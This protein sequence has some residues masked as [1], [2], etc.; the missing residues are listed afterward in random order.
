MR[1]REAC[2]HWN[3]IY[4]L[5]S[6]NKV[7]RLFSANFKTAQPI[8][9]GLVRPFDR[10]DG[11]ANGQTFLKLGSECQIIG[12]DRLNFSVGGARG[13]RA[14]NHFGKGIWVAIM[15]LAEFSD[16]FH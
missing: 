13:D 6:A 16:Y 3:E 5:T 15:I 4:R 11:I 8:I 14:F 10:L 1:T 12:I 7:L 2:R 9:F